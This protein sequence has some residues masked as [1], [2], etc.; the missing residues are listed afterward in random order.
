V[1]KA[2]CWSC[3]HRITV[4]E[5]WREYACGLTGRDVEPGRVK[6]CTEW[7]ERC[8]QSSKGP[9]SSTGT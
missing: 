2:D 1:A 6:E 4:S 5:K 9:T 3:A 7:K 8:E